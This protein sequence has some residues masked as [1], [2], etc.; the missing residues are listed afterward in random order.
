MDVNDPI[1]LSDNFESEIKYNK[2]GGVE[3]G[4]PD[5]HLNYENRGFEIN[6]EG[7][8]NNNEGDNKINIEEFSENIHWNNK[9]KGFLEELNIN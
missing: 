2:Y 1:D 8:I 4:K 9:L 6:N 3:I 7:E 5:Y